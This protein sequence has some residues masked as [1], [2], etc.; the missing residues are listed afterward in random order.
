ML[1]ADHV[2]PQ[3]LCT[4]RK[5]GSRRT[6][7]KLSDDIG[8]KRETTY[9]AR[10]R[11]SQ[12]S[13]ITVAVFGLNRTI[14]AETAHYFY[15]STTFLCHGSPQSGLAFLHDR[16]HNLHLLTNISLRYRFDAGV[17]AFYESVNK[18]SKPPAN[19]LQTLERGQM[20]SFKT[21]PREWRR[22]LDVL[23]YACPGLRSLELVVDQSI[24]TLAPW[25]LGVR[26]VFQHPYGEAP[27][28]EEISHKSFLQQVARL[29]GDSVRLELRILGADTEERRKLVRELEE[30]VR[31]KMG[32]RGMKA[33]TRTCVCGE[34]KLKRA[35]VRHWGP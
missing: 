15:S 33:R 30:Y 20:G 9:F 28:E 27:P 10:P 34:V 5:T 17:L 6:S 24:W 3:K 19:V 8:R 22:L 32:E 11:A 23:V 26:A 16:A 4:L 25:H 13:D 12:S 31:G 29:C 2:I 1:I 14:Y 7:Y 18:L 35:C 21:E